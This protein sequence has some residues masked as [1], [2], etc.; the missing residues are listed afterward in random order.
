[1]RLVSNRAE[2]CPE[3]S[4]TDPNTENPP[5]SKFRPGYF[6]TRDDIHSPINHRMAAERGI[7]MA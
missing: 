7:D 1:L 4:P 2:S 5:Q 6:A 3:S